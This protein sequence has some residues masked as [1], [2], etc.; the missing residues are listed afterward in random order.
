[1]LPQETGDEFIRLQLLL[2]CLLIAKY[3]RNISFYDKRS[4]SLLSILFF[5]Y[6]ILMT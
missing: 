4:I 2:V 6:G 5:R 3:I 1:M